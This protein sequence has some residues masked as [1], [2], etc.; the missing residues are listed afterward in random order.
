MGYWN[1]ERKLGVAGHPDKF[2]IQVKVTDREKRS[3]F[4]KNTFSG[5][6]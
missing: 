2:F 3:N 4:L 6:C 1:P 5:N